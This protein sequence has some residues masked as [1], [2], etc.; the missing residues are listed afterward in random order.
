MRGNRHPGLGKL[1]IADTVF[2]AQFL[3]DLAYSGIMDVRDRWEEMVFDLEI[4]TAEQPGHYPVLSCEIC[5]CLKLVDRPVRLDLVSGCTATGKCVSSTV[6]ANWKT[7]LS[8]KPVTM[9]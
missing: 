1:D 6:C 9:P 7:I 2:I 3:N 5:R 8:T 4:Q